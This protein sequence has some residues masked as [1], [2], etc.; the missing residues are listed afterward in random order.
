MESNALWFSP[1]LPNDPSNI[2]EDK[3]GKK[4]IL[5]IFISILPFYLVN[6]T[7]LESRFRNT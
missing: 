2:F 7:A 3:H 6:F 1:M 4:G 5:F